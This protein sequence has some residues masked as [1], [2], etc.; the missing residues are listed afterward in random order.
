M[1]C[2]VEELRKQ[3]NQLRLDVVKMVHD[4]GDGH[5]GP[6][7][8]AMDM[9]VALYYNVMK[10]D[11]KNPDWEDRDRFIL[12]KGHACTAVY[13][14]LAR[15]G[16]FPI[17]EFGGLRK[18][19]RILQG[20]PT[21]RK[22]PGIDMTSGSLG[23]GL[24]AGTGMAIAAKYNKK[25]Y[26]TYV[27]LGDGELQEGIVWE[28]AMCAKRYSLDN[29]IAFVDQNG[30]QSGG[31]IEECSGLLPIKEKWEAFGWYVQE[32]DG[33]DFIQILEAV[34]NAKKQKGRPSMIVAKT[35]KGKGI[36]YMENDNAWHKKVPDAA[37]VAR[38]VEILGGNV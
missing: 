11:S 8:S 25:D 13:A 37:Q 10:V 19:G 4:A 27:I 26:Y 32:I 22:T 3:A 29:L 23:N 30:W 5:P 12:S 20:H 7:M 15:K 2:N 6:A 1:S 36:D 33:H 24:S 18:M 38:A 14:A 17:E 31:A 16:Y 35:I 9:I 21:M 28:A 34:D